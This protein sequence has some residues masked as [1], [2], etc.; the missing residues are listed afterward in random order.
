MMPA[1]R[2]LSGVDA[3]ESPKGAAAI[4]IGDRDGGMALFSSH[5]PL[6]QGITAVERM[7]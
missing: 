1:L 4:G 7:C 5:P 6:E 3:G 2:R